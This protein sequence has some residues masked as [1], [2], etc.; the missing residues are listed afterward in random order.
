MLLY[1]TFISMSLVHW[2]IWHTVHNQ[3]LYFVNV[4]TRHYF[5]PIERYWNMVKHV[6]QYDQ[7]SNNDGYYLDHSKISPIYEA[8]HVDYLPLKVMLLSYMKIILFVLHKLKKD[9]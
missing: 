9:L 3:I 1:D 2:F 7:S 4:L 8:N 5:A 6:L